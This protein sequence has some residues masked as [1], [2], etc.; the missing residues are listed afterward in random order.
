MEYLMEEYLLTQDGKTIGLAGHAA[1]LWWA[2]PAN[3]LLVSLVERS[4]L[5]NICYN[6]KLNK[7]QKMKQLLITLSTIFDPREIHSSMYKHIKENKTASKI[8]LETPPQSV[9]DAIAAHNARIIQTFLNTRRS[10]P[11]ANVSEA[12]LP[13]SKVCKSLYFTLANS[14]IDQAH[15]KR[16]SSNNCFATTPALDSCSNTAS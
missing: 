10:I 14:H 12:I 6:K 9:I 2:E 11:P 15:I 3:L 13:L 8:V 5:H 1:H 7:E 4:V 16:A